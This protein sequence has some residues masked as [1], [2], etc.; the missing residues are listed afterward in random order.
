[1]SVMQDYLEE[2]L[3]SPLLPT[4]PLEVSFVTEA[5]QA[6]D[7]AIVKESVALESRV[8]LESVLRELE[9]QG[10]VSKTQAMGLESFG[11]RL[12]NINGYTAQPSRTNYQVTMESILGAI[13]ETVRK[14]WESIINFFRRL[15]S[16]GKKTEELAKAAKE[17]TKQRDKEKKEAD[18]EVKKV[19][20]VQE[21]AVAAAAKRPD[22]IGDSAFALKH[23][24]HSNVLY[25]LSAWSTR[26]LAIQSRIAVEPRVKQKARLQE[27]L[28][29]AE[30]AVAA[31]QKGEEKDSNIQ[32]AIRALVDLRP[33]REFQKIAT[34]LVRADLANE[35]GIMIRSKNATQ[36]ERLLGQLD[37]KLEPALKWANKLTG[38]KRN[39]FSEYF[40]ADLV[41]LL[42]NLPQNKSAFIQPRNIPT[43]IE[44]IFKEVPGAV[45]D[46]SEAIQSL[47]EVTGDPIR[48]IE[49]IL[50]GKSGHHDPINS[51]MV[52]R[53]M[54]LLRCLQVITSVLG[55]LSGRQ[56][57]YARL[58]S[59]YENRV[60][61]TQSGYNLRMAALPLVESE[62]PQTEDE[63][64]A[65]MKSPDPLK[66]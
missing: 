33:V 23:S 45:E 32:E 25:E 1:M 15:F 66:V 16:F 36:W 20:E 59:A 30:A 42:E 8:K 43:F 34:D 13:G 39:H 7:E 12:P 27:I 11:V 14:I 10:G 31:L 64:D 35:I 4:D 17:T 5:E 40:A 18:Q 9:A 56:L 24:D 62:I 21:K 58:L 2:G 41:P 52:A 63:L 3:Q 54:K 26:M 29:Y 60:K 51:G 19:K 6:H 37:R 57:R 49:N 61:R 44:S 50:K 22:L 55:H 65:F 46:A 47:T 48:E 38:E 53:A 28:S